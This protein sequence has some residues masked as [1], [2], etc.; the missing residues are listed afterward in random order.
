LTRTRAFPASPRRGRGNRSIFDSQPP[1]DPRY[2]TGRNAQH[3]GGF[4]ADF[5]LGSPLVNE[6]V[7]PLGLKDAF[8]SLSPSLDFHRDT[9]VMRA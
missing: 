3:G 7:V 9:V 8:N 2:S 6:V 4:V 1:H 5:R